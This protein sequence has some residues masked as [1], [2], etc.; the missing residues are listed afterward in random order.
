MNDLND[1]RADLPTLKRASDEIGD[2]AASLTKEQRVLHR[3]M[4]EFLD[5]DWTGAAADAFRKHYHEWAEA[6][7]GL[8]TALGNEAVL[9]SG[10]RELIHE[11]DT[12]ITR[13]I[14]RLVQRLGLI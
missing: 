5:A 6:A 4:A 9:I 3:D 7:A 14:D 10:T 1:L 12:N 13:D 2:I 8:L 11:Q